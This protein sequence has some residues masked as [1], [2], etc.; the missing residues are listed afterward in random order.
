MILP[1]ALSTPKPVNLY[2][3]DNG[4]PQDNGLSPLPV[5]P[6]NQGAGYPLSVQRNPYTHVQTQPPP[7]LPP[8]PAVPGMDMYF[9]HHSTYYYSSHL[10]PPPPHHGAGKPQEYGYKYNFAGSEVVDYKYNIA[11]SEAMENTVDYSKF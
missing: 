2:G 7:Q 1:S 6:P 5:Q 3:G 9:G 8:L 10:Y 11:A 4:M